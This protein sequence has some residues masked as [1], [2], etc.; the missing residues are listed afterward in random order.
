M[1]M[2]PLVNLLR[3][4]RLTSI[5][6][7]GANPIDGDPPYKEMLRQRSCRVIGFDPHPIALERLNASKS[8]LETYL[9]YAVGDGEVHTLNV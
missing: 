2:D 1:E 8:T 7:I 6:D 5:V 4:D 3:A 9:P